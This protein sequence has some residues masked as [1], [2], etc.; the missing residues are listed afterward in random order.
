MLV[1]KVGDR[2]EIAPDHPD[3]AVAQIVLS[4]AMGTTDSCFYSTILT[5]LANASGTGPVPDREQLNFLLAV[6]EG[7]EPRDQL[8]AML[9]AKWPWSTPP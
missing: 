2:L 8:E 9:A 1:S 6:I 3:T 7:I 4:R 5:Q